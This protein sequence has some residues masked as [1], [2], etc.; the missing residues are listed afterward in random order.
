[1]KRAL[2]A[3]LALVAVVLLAGLGLAWKNGAVD[4]PPVH[5]PGTPDWASRRDVPGVDNFGQVGPGVFRGAQPTA[6][7]YASLRKLGVRTIVNLRE[8]H[9]EKEA[10]EAAGLEAVWIPL[11]ADIRGAVPPRAE[12]VARFLAVVLDPAKQPVFFHCAHGKDRTG[13]MCAL[14]R[15]E[16]EGWSREQAYLEME[17]FGFNKVWTSLRDFV[18]AYEPRGTWRAAAAPVGSGAR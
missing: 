13:T 5:V 9:S 12:D 7:G 15:M 10:V 8:L 4:A 6:E 3:V 11:Q 14:Y 18:H 17:A 2:L 16:V 1:M